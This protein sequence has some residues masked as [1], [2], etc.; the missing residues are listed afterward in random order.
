[1]NINSYDE[2]VLKKMTDI[3]FEMLFDGKN[4]EAE[5]LF[6]AVISVSPKHRASILGLEM[7][8]V[9]TSP[10]TLKSIT[11][12]NKIDTQDPFIT[13]IQA[14]GLLQCNEGFYANKLLESVIMQSDS[15][16][17]DLAKIIKY[18]E[19]RGIV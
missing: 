17:K 16:A 18:N 10:I 11:E 7:V 4:T 3:G 1:M 5:S 6:S 2:I 15:I 13:C 8:K 19:I 12:S 9:T 14:L